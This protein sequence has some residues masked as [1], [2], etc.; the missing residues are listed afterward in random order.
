MPEQLNPYEKVEKANGEYHD[1][2][3]EMLLDNIPVELKTEIGVL[4][5]DIFLNMKIVNA[6]LKEHYDP[7]EESEE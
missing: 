4:A 5:N 1:A 3:D 6:K 7:V 2:I